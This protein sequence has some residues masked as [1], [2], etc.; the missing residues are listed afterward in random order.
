M[1][2]IHIHTYCIQ[3]ITRIKSVIDCA[4]H[5]N[6]IFA[7]THFHLDLF[8]VVVTP[9]DSPSTGI[10]RDLKAELNHLAVI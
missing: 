8:R 9:S 7:E 4:L 3:L 1:T 5:C 10:E 6:R 2:G